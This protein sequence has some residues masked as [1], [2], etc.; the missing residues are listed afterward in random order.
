MGN[1]TDIIWFDSTDS[2]NKEARRQ[3]SSLDNLSV[4]SAMTQTDGRGQ[5]GNSWSSAPGEN[6]TFSIVLKNPGLDICDQIALSA[7]ASLSVTDLLSSNGIEA[8]IKWPND[9]Y[10]G[11][12]K[13]CGILIENAL[14]GDKVDWSIIGIGLN[15]NQTDFPSDLPNPTSMVLCSGGNSDF[16]VRLLLEEFMEIFNGYHKR[17]LN[18]NGGLK[19]LRQLYL[20]QLWRKGEESYFIDRREGRND[21]FKGIITGTNDSGMLTIKKEEG[22]LCEFA[23]KELIYII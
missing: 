14:K 15:V 7:L 23:F 5:Q 8:K 18:I 20:S 9:I 21:R 1:K 13:I 11:N 16:D 22:E 12:K 2:T 6:L 10:V 17:Y 3:I 19:K 4:L